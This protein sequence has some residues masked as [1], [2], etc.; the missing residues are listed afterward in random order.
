MNDKS[1]SKWL[2]N[3]YFKFTVSC[4]SEIGSVIWVLSLAGGHE[5]NRSFFNIFFLIHQKVAS[6]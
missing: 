4:F 1:K 6:E 2:Y 5:T 3:I